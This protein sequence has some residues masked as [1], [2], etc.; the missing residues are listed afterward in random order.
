MLERKDKQV[1]VMSIGTAKYV[2]ANVDDEKNQLRK[3]YTVVEAGT[4]ESAKAAPT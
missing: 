2:N 4:S 1:K 3:M